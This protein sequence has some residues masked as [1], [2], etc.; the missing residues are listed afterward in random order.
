M[1]QLH[2]CDTSRRRFI[3]TIFPACTAACLMN[4]NKNAFAQTTNEKKEQTKHKFE[5]TIERELTHSTF[6]AIRYEEFMTLAKALE[7]EWGKDKL[8]AFLT[9]NTNERMFQHGQNQAKRLGDNSLATYV[10]QFRPPNYR[11]T[12]THKIVEDTNTAFQIIVTEC[13]WAKTFRDAGMEDIGYAHICYGDYYWPKGF[14]PKMK[15][16]RDKTLMQ[17]HDCCNH[18]YVMTE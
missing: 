8:I 2:K 4:G 3:T 18:R 1:K 12:L 7:K 17:G 10:K 14:N 16:E 15:M 9:K 13:I 6:C 5:Q 11:N